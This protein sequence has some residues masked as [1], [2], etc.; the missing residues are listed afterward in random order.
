ME[1]INVVILRSNPINPDPRTENEA[2]ALGKN[3][4]NV[5]MLGW[6]R[7]VNSVSVEEKEHYKIFRISLKAPTGIGVIVLWPIWWLLVAI[8]LLRN[9]WDIVHAADFDC[10]PPAYLI[11][12]IKHKKVVY[13]LIDH[14]PDMLPLPHIIHSAFSHINRC[15]INS[16]DAVILIDSCK[17]EQIRGLKQEVTIIYNTPPTTYSFAKMVDND[18]SFKIFYGG[19]LFSDRGI[20]NL[21]RLVKD[22]P[23]ISFEIAGTGPQDIVQ[24]V[25]EVAANH[26]NL[27]YHGL[28]PYSKLQELVSKSQLVYAFYNPNI[29]N[30]VFASPAKLFDSMAGSTAVI[31]NKEIA[32]SKIVEEETC[33]LLV[34]YNDYDALK[35]TIS[36]L[37]ENKNYCMELGT[38]GKKAYDAKYSWAIMEERLLT[39]YQSLSE[40]FN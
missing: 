36:W 32:P 39:L 16:A 27:C 34:P 25:K 23:N 7:K 9:D 3:G 29:R 5:I 31:M 15:L 1:K 40:R 17:I 26:K 37:M 10:Y 21:L 20:K 33:G 12:K 38:N 24:L 8:W 13:D 28:L 14:Y 22:M 19:M 2:T 4:Y 30:N 35:E 18:N 11:S 6:D